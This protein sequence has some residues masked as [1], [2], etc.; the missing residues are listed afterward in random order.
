MSW[1]VEN[2]LGAFN[3]KNNVLFKFQ[4]ITLVCVEMELQQGQKRSS[5]QAR[6]GAWTRMVATSEK[7]RADTRYI[8]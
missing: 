1:T 6:E 5:R 3:Y 4:E 8:L 7:E 2:G